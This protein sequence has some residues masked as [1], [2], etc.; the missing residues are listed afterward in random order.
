MVDKKKPESPAVPKPVPPDLYPRRDRVLVQ[1]LA[2][3]STSK[4]GI[5]IPDQAREK[6][7]RALVVA[8]G[9]G[10]RDADGILHPLDL[11]V[12]DT[13][14]MNQYAGAEFKYAEQEYVLVEEVDILAIVGRNPVGDLR[15]TPGGLTPGGA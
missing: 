6:Q 12:G 13:V 11:A 14:L 1:R 5:V 9:P 10:T 15:L 4:G 2:A 3:E 7:R 8:V